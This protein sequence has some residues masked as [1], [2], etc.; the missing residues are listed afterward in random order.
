MHRCREA[1]SGNR[2]RAYTRRV[3][4]A[5]IG[6]TLIELLVVIAIIAILAAILFP[7]FA[8]A[9]D[10]A[11]QAG[12]LSN[13]R[14]IGT[15]L[16]MYVQ[17]YDERLPNCCRE[18]RAWA[19]LGSDFTGACAQPGIT[20]A[21]PKDTYLGPEQSPPRY[22]QELLHPYAKNAEIWFCPS[23]SRSAFF[24]GNPKW[25]TFAFN[26]TTYIWNFVAN[27]ANGSVVDNPFRKRQ[28]TYISGLAI[29][30]I[31]RPAEA[32]TLWDMPYL[33]PLRAPC[34]NSELKAPHAR[35]IN[36]VYADG[37]AK[38]SAF[39]N[40]PAGSNPC[41]E[42]WWAEHHWEGYYE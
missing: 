29:S 2:R 31:P 34:T 8:Q 24:D 21:T 15:G 33:N 28:Y 4:Q 35:G 40:R 3:G 11:R 26:G 14:Q 13:L 25:P 41:M 1:R 36:V 5:A 7:V 17:D 20:K 27:P 39:E 22:V 12:C 10:K 37:H 16:S 42:D 23:V 19:W 18:G 30:A 38:Y 9:R 6:F 32:P